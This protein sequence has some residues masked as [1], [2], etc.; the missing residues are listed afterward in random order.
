M[1]TSRTAGV[2][3][4]DGAFNAATTPDVSGALSPVVQP[5]LGQFVTGAFCTHCMREACDSES[6]TPPVV[7]MAILLWHR[8]CARPLHNVVQ[9]V[10]LLMT[11]MCLLVGESLFNTAASTGAISQQRRVRRCV[12]LALCSKH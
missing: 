9:A 2:F 12:A 7:Y 4:V 1:R 3:A 10:S 5:F 11:W 8:P 6:H